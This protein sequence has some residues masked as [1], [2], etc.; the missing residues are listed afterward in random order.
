MIEIIKVDHNP[1]TPKPFRAYVDGD[2]I[3]NKKGDPKKFTSILEALSYA[4]RYAE[5]GAK[6]GK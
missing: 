4:Q 5:R 3:R 6:R 2:Q 1:R